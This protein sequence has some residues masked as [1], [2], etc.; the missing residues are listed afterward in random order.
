MKSGEASFILPCI[1]RKAGALFPGLKLRVTV[2]PRQFIIRKAGMDCPGIRLY[3]IYKGLRMG[4]GNWLPGFFYGSDM[5]S[6]LLVF[7]ILSDEL[8][9][10]ILQTKS[11]DLLGY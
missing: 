10:T 6:V 2:L 3:S 7:E 9:H 8:L 4:P 5:E 1:I 11:I